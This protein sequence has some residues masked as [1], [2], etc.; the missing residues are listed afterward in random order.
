MVML[1]DA[2]RRD[3]IRKEVA[4]NFVYFTA[5]T[6]SAAIEVNSL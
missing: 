4:R 1:N 3:D 6:M 5:K 2:H